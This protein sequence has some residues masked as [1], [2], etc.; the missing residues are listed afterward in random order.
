MIVYIEN[1]VFLAVDKSTFIMSK[2]VFL[3][4]D[5]KMKR[6]VDEMIMQ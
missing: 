3:W 1:T 5:K 2:N 6:R 4:A